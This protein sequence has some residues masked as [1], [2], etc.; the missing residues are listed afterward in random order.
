M[1]GFI[2]VETTAR[3]VGEKKKISGNIPKAVVVRPNENTGLSKFL[4]L[5]LQI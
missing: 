4:C 5:E 3:L 1:H 2:F